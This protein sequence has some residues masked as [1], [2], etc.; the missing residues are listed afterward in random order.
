MIGSRGEDPRLG[1]VE[2]HIQNAQVLGDCM[3]LEHLHRDDE[4]VL[5]QIAT[6]TDG[7]TVTR[8]DLYDWHKLLEVLPHYNLA[9]GT[10]LKVE[11]Y[12]SVGYNFKKKYNIGKLV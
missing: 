11:F 3:S 5:E 8:S 6:E 12:S 4:G 10:V 9:R 7:R 1:R 2:G